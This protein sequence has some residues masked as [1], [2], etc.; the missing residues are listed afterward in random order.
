MR[1]LVRPSSKP[2]SADPGA[3]R[4]AA[5]RAVPRSPSERPRDPALTELCHDAVGRLARR[6]EEQRCPL[7]CPNDLEKE[8]RPEAL[9]LWPVN[10]WSG[11]LDL[12]QRPLGPEPSALPNCA[13]S[14][15]MPI[16]AERHGLS[17]DRPKPIATACPY[18]SPPDCAVPHGMDTLAELRL[19]TNRLAG[20]RPP[21]FASLPCCRSY[22][23]RAHR[24]VTQRKRTAARARDLSSHHALL[25]TEPAGDLITGRHEAL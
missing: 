23:P 24:G 7:L 3:N 25:C 20:D 5:W 1:L 22:P 9:G 8:K 21:I 11:R 6:R 4:P 17:H 16:S 15:I 12:N 10:L 14:R 13:T 2:R 18:R 19:R